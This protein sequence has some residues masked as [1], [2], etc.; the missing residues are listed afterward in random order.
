VS[1][2]LQ[3]LF[4][5]AREAAPPR[6]W[7]RG[8]E[9][10]RADAVD[11]IQDGDPVELRVRVPGKTIAPQ[12]TLHI[13][14]AEWS[15]TCDGDDPCEHVVAAVLAIRQAK[16]E[17]RALGTSRKAGADV[18]YRLSR[19]GERV[20]VARV[21]VEAGAAEVVI[22]GTLAGQLSGR[23]KGPALELTAVDLTIDQFLQ[24]SRMRSLP[25]DRFLTLVNLL[26]QARDVRLD[27]APVSVAV[28]PFWPE[29]AV[30]RRGKGFVLSLALPT[31]GARVEPFVPGLVLV[32]GRTLR[33]IGEP[34]LVGLRLE[35]LPLEL[36]YDGERVAELVTRVLPAWRERTEVVE[37]SPLPRA[38]GALSAVP[39]LDVVQRGSRLHVV[40]SIGYGDPPVARLVGDRIEPLRGARV[41]V[42]ARDPRA[43]RLAAERLRQLVDLVPG[44]ALDVTGREA[45]ALAAT[46]RGLVDVAVLGD[47]HEVNYPRS[48]AAELRVTDEAFDVAF[49]TEGP[50]PSL[51]V[52]ATAVVE[53]WREGLGA[54]PLLGGGFAPLPEEWL[55]RHGDRLRQLLAARDANGRVPAH[56]RPSLA[57]LCSDL[58]HP[59]P[60]ELA[61][62][63]PLARDFSGIPEATLPAV[64]HAELRPYQRRGVDWLSFLRDA[65]LG[66]LLADDMGLGKT[67]QTL[68]VL[69]GRALVVCPR[70]VVHNWL[71]ELARFRPDVPAVAYHGASRELPDRGVV[72][73]TYALLRREVELFASVTWDTVVLD[74][75]QAVKNPDSQVAEAARRLR[76]GFRVALSGTPVE[77]RLEELWSLMHFLN[78]GLLGGRT[79]FR[80][81]IE[82]PVGDGAADAALRLRER[83]RPFVL[84]R[85]KREVASDLPPRLDSVLSCELDDDERAVYD[86]VLLATRASVM[87]ELGEGGNVMRALEALLR[88]RQAACDVTLLPGQAARPEPSSK[89]QRLR[90]ALEEAAGGGHRAL[91]FSQW[92]SL[93]NR[94]EPELKDAGLAFL[95]LDG[96]TSDREGVVKAFQADDGP[97]VMLLSLKAGGTGLNLTAADHVFLLDPWWN[98][99]VEDQAAD[100][101]H[102]IGQTRS[103]LVHRLIARDTVEERILDLQRR[104]RGLAEAALDEAATALA[105]TRDDLLALV[106]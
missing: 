106:Q 57:R 55:A 46:L 86:A 13:A 42:F 32:E 10:Q 21:A 53:A 98:P 87:K 100:R 11:L 6:T 72:V 45:V 33:P 17:G 63:A 89:L 59:T 62:L 44:R 103:V 85:T 75:A 35:R 99:A 26:A 96:S 23:E 64:L 22:E 20:L 77:N 91:V 70:S 90:A 83:I 43:E 60:P 30:E 66:A 104:K 97:P 47:A 79:A 80:D 29:V 71:D 58:E 105:L 5:A 38:D 76:A 84:R 4:A 39:M 56:A 69:A 52:D 2:P 40:A 14:D 78:P 50:G 15:C 24:Q 37:R 7:S 81:E 92:T 18:G 1:D 54:V 27:G 31:E 12:A 34:E 65:G 93:L 36:R 73:T 3:A 101:A 82:R 74:E 88:L 9:L 51:V 95:R 16:K 25:A 19:D 49:A 68:T 8:V 61:R 41:P 67:L 94:V 28:E 102:R 48:L